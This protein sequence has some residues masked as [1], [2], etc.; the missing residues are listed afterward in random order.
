M[1]IA[2]S[3]H[4]GPDYRRCQQIWPMECRVRLETQ[5]DNILL[6]FV[7]RILKW[8]KINFTNNLVLGDISLGI[9]DSR[10]SGGHGVSE[11]LEIGSVLAEFPPGLLDVLGQFIQVGGSRIGGNYPLETVHLFSIGFRS[12]D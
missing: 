3:R 4:C 2:G 7:T 1:W 5:N 11:R 8:V 9:D 6:I 12:L 10:N